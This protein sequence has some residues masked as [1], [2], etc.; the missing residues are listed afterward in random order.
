M[1]QE[2]HD[3]VKAGDIDLLEDLL[4]KPNADI[5]MVYVSMLW[6]GLLS[7]VYVCTFGEYRKCASIK[8]F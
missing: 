6:E 7:L 4:D 5:T 8:Q 1:T 3:A 2:M